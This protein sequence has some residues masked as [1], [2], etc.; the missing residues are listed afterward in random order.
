MLDVTS[1]VTRAGAPADPGRSRPSAPVA[2]G[3]DAP[4]NGNSVPV[5]NAE[6]TQTAE[7]PEL[8]RLAES[9]SQF[10]QSMNRDLT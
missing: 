7:L 9:I 3:Q 4:V 6:K 5:D 2:A 10:A 1:I 8:E